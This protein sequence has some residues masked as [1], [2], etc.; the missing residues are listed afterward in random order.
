MHLSLRRR[1][2]AEDLPFQPL[3]D[4]PEVDLLGKV[5]VGFFQHLDTQLDAA[6]G[7]GQAAGF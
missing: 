6:Q 3:K 2:A 4:Q 7:L 5:G 1:H